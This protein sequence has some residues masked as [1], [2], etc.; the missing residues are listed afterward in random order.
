VGI[1]LQIRE[2]RGAF[3][4]DEPQVGAIGRLLAI[5]RERRCPSVRRVVIIAV[6]MDSISA[7]NFSSSV[8]IQPSQTA[9]QPLCPCAKL[10]IWCH[11]FAA[12]LLQLCS[13]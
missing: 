5:A 9:V 8:F 12:S 1:V 3:P 11:S 7:N 4:A 6:L 2:L 10:I 13:S